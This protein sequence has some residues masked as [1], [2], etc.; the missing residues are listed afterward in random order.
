MQWYAKQAD[1]TYDDFVT[2]LYEDTTLPARPPVEMPSAKYFEQ[3]GTVAM[4]SSLMDPKR[5]SLFFKSSPFGSLNH[6]HADQNNMIGISAWG[7]LSNSPGL[8]EVLEAPPGFV[9]DGFGGVKEAMYLFLGANAKII[10]PNAT[11][12]LKL[13]RAGSGAATPSDQSADVDVI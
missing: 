12:T 9:F 4:H 3:I 5:I 2:Y 13:R 1:Y 7:T 6:S 8:Y 10:V 11:G